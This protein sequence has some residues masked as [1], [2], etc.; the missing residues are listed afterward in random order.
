MGEVFSVTFMYTSSNEQLGCRG[1]LR[2][3]KN[4]MGRV[5]LVKTMSLDGGNRP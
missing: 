5:V 3:C 2:K 4:N 1:S